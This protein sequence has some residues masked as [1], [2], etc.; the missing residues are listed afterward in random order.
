M[1]KGHFLY[2]MFKN[3]EKYEEEVKKEHDKQLRESK[4]KIRSKRFK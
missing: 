2:R 1:A 3:W 4:A